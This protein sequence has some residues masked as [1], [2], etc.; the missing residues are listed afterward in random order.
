M[1]TQTLCILPAKPTISVTN[2]AGQS[3]LTSSSNEGNH[4]YFSNSIID[5][6]DEKT[7]VAEESGLYKVNVVIDNCVSAFSDDELIVITGT[8]TLDKSIKFY[9]NPVVD[10]LKIET[11]GDTPHQLTLFDLQG[12][13]L[14]TIALDG[15]TLVDYPTG[16]LPRGIYLIKIISGQKV[17]YEKFV[18]E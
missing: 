10:N 8:E 6:A 3:V 12:K 17:S 2:A 7:F 5:D 11:T 9:P 16:S 13:P 4:W 15:N 14:N 18:K 1:E